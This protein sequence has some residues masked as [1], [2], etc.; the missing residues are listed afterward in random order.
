MA[1]TLTFESGI[2]ATVDGVAVTSP[3]TLTKSCKLEF[4]IGGRSM[5]VNGNKVYGGETETFDL[6]DVDIVVEIATGLGEPGT[7]T[8]AIVNYI[9]SG[10]GDKMTIDI[11]KSAGV[12]LK[13]QGK[14]CD[15][16]ITV[17]PVL[18]EKSVTPT[19]SAQEV[20]PSTGKCG[21]GKVTVGAVQTETKSVTPSTSQQTVTPTSGKYL[22]QV[23][24]GAIQAY[25]GN[26]TPAKGEQTIN[27]TSGKF[28][29]SFKVGAIPSDYIIPSGTQQIT[30]N[31]TYD[32][33]GKANAV[34]NVPTSGSGVGHTVTF[35]SDGSTVGASFVLEGQAI[36]QPTITKQGYFLLG[37]FTAAEGGTAVEFPYAPTADVTF[38]ARWTQQIL[39]G[40]TG[41]TDSS[42]GLT[43]TDDIA[44][45]EKYMINEV[46][47]Y[48]NVT[49]PL[50]NMFPFNR[51]EE[52]TDTNGNV[53]VK[54]PRFY[55]KW[56]LDA[57]GNI[58]GYKISDS[59]IDED[60]FVPDAF[61][62]PASYGAAEERYLDY[63]ALGKYEG[64]GSSSKVFS[65]SGATCLVNITRGNF[66]AGCR[67]YG[68]SANYYNGYQQLDM[69][70]YVCYNLLCMLYYKTKN[71]QTVYGGRTGAVSG[72]SWSVASVTGTCDNVQGLNGWN[73]TTDCVKML[74]V[75]NPYGN[76]YKWV[77]G[78]WFSSSTIYIQRSPQLFADSSSGA[79]TMGFS[80]P[81]SSNWIR[82][83][84]KGTSASTRSYAYVSDA[85]SAS[86]DTYYGD[87]S[88]YSS[89]GTVLCVG[90]SWSSTSYAGLWYFS[91]GASAS[92][93]GSSI[94]GRLS[95]R[96][97][98][99]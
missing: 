63:F 95:Y 70:Q 34:V 59:K 67:A 61:L 3:Y 20:T 35:I 88:Y 62:G 24:V 21:M 9:I 13:T 47:N 60:Y 41:L 1:H 80:R 15:K 91:G 17:V 53:F 39:I 72:H 49:S 48:V 55:M 52:F 54:F 4:M 90:G 82:Y 45:V 26:A 30:E 2:T 83:L 71:I 57:S 78:I 98:S 33:S 64:S 36:T 37:W 76:I 38:Y 8:T 40:V 68:S 18:E 10:G 85:T 25:Q 73:V 87:Y 43:Y 46:G 51:I 14:Y 66:R 32:V 5:K 84:K 22:K 89:S 50:D 81:T 56:L 42:S 79:V 92:S 11:T 7:T 28:F 86:S 6:A 44:N 77:D 75:E 12:V 96:P 29:S 99:V 97:V 74:G 65:K 93:A 23:N 27:P 69:S 94:G 16:D 58:D 19:E 31:G